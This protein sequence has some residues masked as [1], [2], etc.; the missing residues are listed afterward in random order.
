M[1]QAPS[2]RRPCGQAGL[3]CAGAAAAGSVCSATREDGFKK[4]CTSGCCQL[5]IMSLFYFCKCHCNCFVSLKVRIWESSCCTRILV[6]PLRK[7]I[8]R[9]LLIFTPP[10]VFFGIDL[11]LVSCNFYFWFVWGFFVYFYCC[12]RA[13]GD[14]HG[15]FFNNGEKVSFCIHVCPDGSKYLKS[16]RE[17]FLIAFQ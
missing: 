17:W 6:F 2:I 1:G 5:S 11:F 16:R 7:L 15:L 8:L 12:S 9:C 4:N 13:Y 10:F 14:V 3:P